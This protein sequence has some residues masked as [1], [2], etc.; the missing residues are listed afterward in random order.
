MF[1]KQ[2]RENRS[3]RMRVLVC[4][5]L[6]FLVTTTGCVRESVDGDVH[7]FT[8]EL[9]ISASILLAGV[10]AGVGGW[11]FRKTKYG[12][13]AMIAGP[14]AALLFAPSIFLDHATVDDSSFK[15]NTGIWGLTAV[16]EVKFDEVRAIKIISEVVSG[17]RG[18]KSTNYYLLCSKTEG[19]DA[20]IPVNNR[21]CEE[22][23]KLFLE[24]A[25]EKGIII[26]DQT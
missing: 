3:G 17:R 7:S 19:G 6:L 4:G 12:W 15:V 16:H 10:L 23:A 9:W 26:L 8:N 14:I 1:K 11:F 22:A 20:K 25:S 24:R 5:L 13:A 21:V 18:R 2:N